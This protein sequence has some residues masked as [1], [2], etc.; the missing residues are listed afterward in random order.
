MMARTCSNSIEPS[1]KYSKAFGALKLTDTVRGVLKGE[2]RHKAS[3]TKQASYASIGRARPAQ[4]GH[5]GQAS[6]SG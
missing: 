3:R 4:N 2:T 1:R 5:S 6:P